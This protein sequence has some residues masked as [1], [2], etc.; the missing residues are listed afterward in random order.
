MR[1]EVIEPR[2][3]QETENKLGVITPWVSRCIVQDC[4]LLE[5]LSSEKA[6]LNNTRLNFENSL[7]SGF[8]WRMGPST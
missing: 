6:D 7:A 1:I 3:L 2:Q 4:S 8:S 5:G